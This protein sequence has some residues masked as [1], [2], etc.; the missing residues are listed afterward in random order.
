MDDLLK[1]AN[2]SPI[3]DKIILLDCCRAGNMGT[4]AFGGNAAHIG[5]GIVILAASRASESALEINGHGV[6]TSLLL[7][8]A[9]WGGGRHYGPGNSYPFVRPVGRVPG[10]YGTAAAVQSQCQPF[11]Y[12]KECCTAD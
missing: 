5:E 9:R 8:G 3:T 2:A 6:F 1:I 10:L 4:P 7:A 12:Y 11:C